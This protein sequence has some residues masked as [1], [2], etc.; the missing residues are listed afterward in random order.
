MLIRLWKTQEASPGSRSSSSSSHSS[1]QDRD[2]PKHKSSSAMNKRSKKIS[3]K[4]AWN[5]GSSCPR[6][7]K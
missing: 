2:F 3:M 6:P 1:K 7:S 5:R 4:K